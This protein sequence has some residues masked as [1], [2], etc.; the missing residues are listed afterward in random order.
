[1]IRSIDKKIWL[2]ELCFDTK[3]ISEILF[4]MR[5]SKCDAKK[6]IIFTIVINNFITSFCINF[7]HYY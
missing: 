4:T 6:I 2:A 7:Y 3:M 1:M 5:M